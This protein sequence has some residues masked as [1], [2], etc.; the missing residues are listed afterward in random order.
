M[1]HSPPMNL[2]TDAVYCKQH[3]P[4]N[5]WCKIR[6]RVFHL[7]DHR[8]P[9]RQADRWMPAH[10]L[11]ACSHLLNFLHPS[12]KLD[13]EHSERAWQSVF[14]AP[15]TRSSLDQNT[16]SLHLGLHLCSLLFP[17]LVRMEQSSKLLLRCSLLPNLT[18]TNCSSK[19]KTP[20]TY[21]YTVE[22]KHSPGGPE[23]GRDPIHHGTT[24]SS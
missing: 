7:L 8:T 17:H 23:S 19:D 20:N 12:F 10:S 24:P 18:V 22:S 5:P 9:G 14:G 1:S 16:D 4:S 15:R 6:N 2:A 3:D 11:E 13:V 21:A